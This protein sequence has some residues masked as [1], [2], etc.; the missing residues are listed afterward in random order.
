MTDQSFTRPGAVDLSTLAQQSASH[1]GA[2]YVMQL[3]EASFDS[4]VARSMQYPV[5]IELYSPRANA[6]SVSDT[7]IAETNAAGGKWLLARVNVD[8]EQRIAAAMQVQAVPT[9][10]AVIGGQVA[11]LFQGTRDE[12]E[13]KGVLE[14]LSQVAIANGLTGRAEPVAGGAVAAQPG[15]E[16]GPAKPA[17]DPRFAAADAALAAGDFATAVTEFEKMLAA[18]PADA[19]AQQG[20]A[21]SKL[22]QRSMEFN[23]AE[24]VQRSAAEPDDI[25]V[26]LQAAD[27]ELINGDAAASFER[28]LEL[29]RENR[30]ADVREQLRLRLLELFD[31]V[32]K[33]D[34]A[35]LKA[36][37]K[38]STALFA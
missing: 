8:A 11:P 32:G 1:G 29:V 38:L 36:R 28:I 16:G 19:E 5:V 10:M 2:S 26:Q 30:D 20:L 9:V 37:R 6:Q 14:Q 17:G 4:V 22:F 15:A 7:L 13:I 21:Q 27:L 31:A 34:P 35:V 33:A 25:E 24:V 23:P 12:A 3:D 18:T